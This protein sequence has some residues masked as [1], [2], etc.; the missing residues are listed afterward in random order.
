M[1]QRQHAT[2]RGIAWR[3]VGCAATHGE[4]MQPS[5]PASEYSIRYSSTR[6]AS[7][8]STTKE[9]TSQSRSA[10]A[11]TSHSQGRSRGSGPSPQS[12]RLGG[13]A[14]AVNNGRSSL[15]LRRVQQFDPPMSAACFF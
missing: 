9:V 10:E 3:V 1:Q 6:A 5:L 8:C 12:S 7:S 15:I 2:R 11:A 14:A 13:A 4:Q